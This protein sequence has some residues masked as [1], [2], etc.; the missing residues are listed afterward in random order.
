MKKEYVKPYI[1]VESFQLNAAIASSCSSE[2]KLPLNFTD[3]TC[4][5]STGSGY[6]GD[7]CGSAGGID[8]TPPYDHGGDDNDG[9][10]YHGPVTDV[11]DM[12][13]NS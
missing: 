13:M 1:A 8:M 2:N 6:F 9:L 3:D 10:C 11:A 12:F 7:A 4:V 5:D